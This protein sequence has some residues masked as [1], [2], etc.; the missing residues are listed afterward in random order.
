MQLSEEYLVEKMLPIKLVS[1]RMFDN[2]LI[3]VRNLDA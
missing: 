1:T 2:H 3:K